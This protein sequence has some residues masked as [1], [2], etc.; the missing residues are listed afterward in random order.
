MSLKCREVNRNSQNSS[1]FLNKA[2]K[3]LSKY[4][5][6]LYK[7][8]L[9]NSSGVLEASETYKVWKKFKDDKEQLELEK[10]KK[11]PAPFKLVKVQ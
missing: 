8:C 1:V 5:Y 3:N 4:P 6:S 9:F 2:K 7:C 11:K 10:T